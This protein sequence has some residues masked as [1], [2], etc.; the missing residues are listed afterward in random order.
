VSAFSADSLQVL[1]RDAHFLVLAKPAGIA[2][3]APDGGASLFALARELDP[4]APQLHPLSRLDTQVTGIVVFARDATTNRLVLEA[5]RAGRVQRRYLGLCRRAPEPPLGE[6]RAAIG[7]DARD[8]K[9]R[10]ALAEGATG[11][12]V[13]DAHT[14][15]GVRAVTEAVVALDLWPQT[16]RTHQLR[17]HAAHAGVPLLGDVAYGGER[18]IVLPN[19]RILSAGRVMLHCVEVRLPHPDPARAE[20][21]MNMP[22]VQDMGTL[23]EAAGGTSAAL[24]EAQSLR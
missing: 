23:W 4:R 21:L 3:T 19:G 24:A 15:Y 18:R 17:V 12:G 6:W 9:K 5:R 8:P 16:G 11:V 2:T 1:Y 14:R 20:L 22:P 13:K 7:M 10:R